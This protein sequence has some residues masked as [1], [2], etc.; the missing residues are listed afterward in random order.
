MCDGP[1]MRRFDLSPPSAV[2]K[3]QPGQST[4]SIIGI[5]NILAETTIPDRPR[6][7][8]LNATTLKFK[9]RR[10]LMESSETNVSDF[11]SDSRKGDFFAFKPSREYTKEVDIR[12]WPNRASDQTTRLAGAGLK[13]TLQKPRFGLVG[14]K[15]LKRKKRTRF[16]YR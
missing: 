12:N 5:N 14:N 11:S 8:F 15:P 9:L 4:A 7:G 1:N 16:N 3:L 2:D 13:A 6:E 10:Q